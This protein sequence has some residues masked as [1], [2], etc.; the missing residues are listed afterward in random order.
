M[1]L[2]EA[3][4]RVSVIHRGIVRAQI[5]HGYR[6]VPTFL[7]G[8]MAFVACAVQGIWLDDDGDP[9][10]CL[11]LWLSAAVVSVGIVAVEMFI[12]Y[13]RS[14][15]T[16][17]RD[18]TI[19]SAEQF[20]PTL[21]AGALLTFV[22]WQF[23]P[24][25]LLWLLPG[26]WA[27]MLSMGI[28][29]SRKMLPPASVIVGAHYLMTGLLCIAFGQDKQFFPAWAMA[30]TFGAGQFLAAAILYWSL[31]RKPAA[32]APTAKPRGA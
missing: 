12:R 3:L 18:M 7:S 29:A 2:E 20:I 13:K 10:A 11:M 27:V 21:V 19:G 23:V 6:A 14:T 28:F 4:Q 22:F 5:F 1:E 24:H 26:L 16:L 15:S 31:E 9:F 30:V 25:E 17:E 32:S 8:L